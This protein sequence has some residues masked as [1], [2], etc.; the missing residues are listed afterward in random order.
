MRRVKP[1]IPRYSLLALFNSID[2]PHFDYCSAVWGNCSNSL[3]EKQKLQNR[4]ATVFTGDNYKY[5][6]VYI[7]MI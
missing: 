4:A 3:Q 7:D 6:D 1:F 2:Q 5:I